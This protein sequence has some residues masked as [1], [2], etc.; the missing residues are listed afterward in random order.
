MPEQIIIE[1]GCLIPPVSLAG[2]VGQKNQG[3]VVRKFQGTVLNVPIQLCG[4]NPRRISVLVV[5]PSTGTD[6]LD[7]HLDRYDANMYIRL[8][9][10][11]SLL[12]NSDFPWTGVILGYS[13]AAP[14]TIAQVLEVSVQ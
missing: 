10:G 4:V 3:R 5:N 14:G 9:I 7:V 8:L 13:S 1:P 2:I 6:Y 11:D 12:I